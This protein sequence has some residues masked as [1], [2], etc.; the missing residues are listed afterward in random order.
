MCAQQSTEC[1]VFL[2]GKII[3]FKD[4]KNEKYFKHKHLF[5]ERGSVVSLS[6]REKKVLQSSRDRQNLKK[7]KHFDVFPLLQSLLDLLFFKII[8]SALVPVLNGNC[9]LKIAFR[10]IIVPSPEEIHCEKYVPFFINLS[11]LGVMDVFVL[12]VNLSERIESKLRKKI[13]GF[14]YIQLNI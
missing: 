5:Y 7:T 2:F 10:E 3:S 13:F 12:P 11:R 6:F 9:V 4:R 8:V 14:I 1:I